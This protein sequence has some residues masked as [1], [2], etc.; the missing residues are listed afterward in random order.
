MALEQAL[1]H[2]DGGAEVVTEGHEQVDVVEIFGAAETVG[3][4]VARVDGRLHVAA[5][6]TEEAVVA[7]AYFGRRPVAAEGGDRDGHGQVVAKSTQQLFGDHALL[8]RRRLEVD[9][10]GFFLP[11]GL[12]QDA[13]DV[14]DVDG[15]VGRTHRLDQAADAEVAGLA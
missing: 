11:V 4:I 13:V 5:V 6:G 3:E 2:S 14:V 10:V 9:E 12:H 8:R 1:Q 15:S 7:S